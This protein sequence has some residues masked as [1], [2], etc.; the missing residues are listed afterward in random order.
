MRAWGFIGIV[1]LGALLLVFTV[2]WIPFA[3]IEIC[4]A[5]Y[6]DISLFS[7]FLSKYGLPDRG[8]K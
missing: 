4:R 5:Y 8:K 2:L 7:C 1:G 6:K 3:K